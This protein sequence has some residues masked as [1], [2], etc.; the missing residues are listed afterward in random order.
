[1]P[2]FAADEVCLTDAIDAVT[3]HSWSFWDAMIWATAKRA[4]CR[5]LLSEDGQSGRTLGG[6]TIINPFVTDISPLLAEALG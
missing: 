5:L 4:G 1:M 2:V 3:V 6:V